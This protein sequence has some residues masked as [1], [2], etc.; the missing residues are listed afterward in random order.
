LV[1]KHAIL[2]S[3]SSEKREEQAIDKR[4]VVLGVQKSKL[5]KYSDRWK[6]DKVTGPIN[7]KNS[8]P[9]SIAKDQIHQRLSAQ[10]S[11]EI[12]ASADWTA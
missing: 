9:Q 8:T 7:W 12:G 11:P 2:A 10:R 6:F 4:D 5:L 3:S 1:Q